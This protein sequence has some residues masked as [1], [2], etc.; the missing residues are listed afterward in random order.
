MR[1]DGLP[2]D[3]I[4]IAAGV[5]TPE[6]ASE[7][8]ADVRKSGM[9]MVSFKPGSVSAINQVVNIAQ[10]NPD[11]N[12]VLQWTGPAEVVITALRTCISH[13]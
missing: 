2:I 1:E 8:L 12:I 7:V 13:C 3:S 11:I 5:P 10:Q 9:R 4:T 6:R